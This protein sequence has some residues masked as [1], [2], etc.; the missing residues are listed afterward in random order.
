MTKEEIR[1][2]LVTI[3]KTMD[4]LIDANERRADT[5]QMRV[6]R[7]YRRKLAEELRHAK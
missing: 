4:K 6:L 1:E 5:A 2:R 7:D 3:H